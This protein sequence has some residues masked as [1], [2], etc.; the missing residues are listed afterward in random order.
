MREA[1]QEYLLAHKHEASSK[2]RNIPFIVG[3]AAFS[4]AVLT[5]LVLAEVFPSRACWHGSLPLQE[6]FM[7]CP[8]LGSAVGSHCRVIDRVLDLYA[9]QAK[10][11]PEASEVHEF[12]LRARAYA[13]GIRVAL[14]KGDHERAA[15]YMEV[16][17]WLMLQM[18]EALLKP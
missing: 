16:L 2:K 14:A 10:A 6:V 15:L 12:L 9:V 1:G 18:L 4:R 17:E 3:L 11:L 8:T 13:E 5:R 7:L